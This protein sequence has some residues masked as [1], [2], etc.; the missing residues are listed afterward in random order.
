LCARVVQPWCRRDVAPLRC[1]TCKELASR[2]EE[3]PYY[4]DG[5]R[6]CS[7]QPSFR[8]SWKHST[9]VEM[10]PSLPWVLRNL[11]NRE[12]SLSTLEYYW[13]VVVFRVSIEGSRVLPGNHG[14]LNLGD[15]PAI[16]FGYAC[17]F[18]AM[19]FEC[20]A[21]LRGGKTRALGT[22]RVAPSFGPASPEVTR[23]IDVGIWA[24]NSAA[25]WRCS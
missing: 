2:S 4:S 3:S 8:S 15:F 12:C 6:I 13:Q 11:W 1:G 18:P 22:C 9:L 7:H 16:G 25:R 10:D 24:R 5:A 20:N 21:I 17:H 19:S 14:Q 23:G